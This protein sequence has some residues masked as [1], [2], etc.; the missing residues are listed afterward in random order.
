MTTR[1]FLGDQRVDQIDPANRGLAYGDG[2]FETMRVY[3]GEIPWLPA[4]LARLQQGAER[5]QIN[6]DHLIA[7]KSELAHMV[8]GIEQGLLKLSLIRGGSTRGYSSDPNA[9]SV[10][11][12]ALYP[13]PPRQPAPLNLVVCKQFLGHVPALAGIKHLNRLE[14]VLLRQEVQRQAAD[15]GICRDHS[16][17]VVCATAAN[18]V[19]EQQGR[20]YTPRIVG[21]GIAGVCRG[22]LL[23]QSLIAECASV[24]VSEL[25]GSRSVFLCNAARGIL[26]VARIADT[27][28]QSSPLLDKLIAQFESANPMFSK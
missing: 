18:V 28:F 11:V 8:H 14:Q 21:A 3:R 7:I 20:W 27:R 24:A 26:P 19:F 4:H 1:I 15:E 10:W 5:L 25:L 16:G 13:V 9:P 2:L 12:L 23:D 6:A 22:W 17:S